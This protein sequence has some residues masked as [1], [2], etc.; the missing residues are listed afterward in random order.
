MIKLHTWRFVCWGSN[1]I[2]CK[3]IVGQSQEL[4]IS[5]KKIVK[6]FREITFSHKFLVLPVW[7]IHAGIRRWNLTLFCCHK[8]FLVMCRIIEK[9]QKV[10][11]RWKINENFVEQISWNHVKSFFFFLPKGTRNFSVFGE[12]AIGVCFWNL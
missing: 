12:T 11:C 7:V 10:E 8:L 4:K 6:F 5:E 3:A 9:F 2:K 1:K